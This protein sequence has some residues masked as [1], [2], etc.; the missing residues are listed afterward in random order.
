VRRLSAALVNDNLLLDM[1]P[2]VMSAARE[3]GIDLSA[4][5][6]VLQTHH[7]TDHLYARVLLA[8][9]D[10]DCLTPLPTLHWF[11]GQS[12]IDL[13]AHTARRVEIGQDLQERLRFA[14]HLVAAGERFEVGPY[15]VTAVPASH[16]E[17]AETPLLYVVSDAGRT[18]FYATDTGVFSADAWATLRKVRDRGTRFDLVVLDESMGAER[19]YAHHLNIPEAIEHIA[20]LRDERLL[21]L[22]ARV[23][24]THLL[25]TNPPHDELAA[26]LAPHGIEVPYDGLVVDM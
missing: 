3:F 20:R 2:E 1:G 24:V 14:V 17:V 15:D 23:F 13:L 18:L 19:Q 16:G 6:Y 12:S 10:F 8:R 5:H 9:S 21:A 25:H 26:L 22:R 7:H 4:L 11:A